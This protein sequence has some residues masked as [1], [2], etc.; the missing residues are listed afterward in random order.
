M[1][2]QTYTR[3][4]YKKEFKIKKK[5]SHVKQNNETADNQRFHSED[6][7]TRGIYWI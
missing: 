2:M 4:E 1:Y 3:K 6:D 7:K 5:N